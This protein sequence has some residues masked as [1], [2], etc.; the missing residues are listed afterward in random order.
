[1]HNGSDSFVDRFNRNREHAVW[2]W[3]AQVRPFKT[4]RG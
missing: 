1:M 3:R 4:G 2:E